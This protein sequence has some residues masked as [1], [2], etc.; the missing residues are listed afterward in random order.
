MAQLYY[1]NLLAKEYKPLLDARNVVIG[2]L[3]SFDLFFVGWRANSIAKSNLKIA[4]Q[5]ENSL[6]WGGVNHIRLTVH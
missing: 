5:K 2:L 1:F 6:K 3:I 4:Q